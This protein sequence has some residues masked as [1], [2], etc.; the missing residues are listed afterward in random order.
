MSLSW[1]HLLTHAPAPSLGLGG[2]SKSP[3]TGER[4][5]RCRSGGLGS[6]ERRGR[7]CGLQPLILQFIDSAVF[8]LFFHVSYCQLLAYQ[9]RFSGPSFSF[10]CTCLQPL[11]FHLLSIIL[12]WKILNF[13]KSTLLCTSCKQLSV[14]LNTKP[15]WLV[16]L[17]F[18]LFFYFFCHAMAHVGS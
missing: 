15:Y 13:I 1:P 5:G 14:A 12:Y 16:L 2:C 3:P 6:S 10:S 4:R 17:C 7:W 9:F 8:S 18:V 11:C